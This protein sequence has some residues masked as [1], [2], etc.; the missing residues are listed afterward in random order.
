MSFHT[1]LDRTL[2]SH[3]D[4]IELPLRMP[5]NVENGPDNAGA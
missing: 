5:A 1:D 3:L 2:H 4:V